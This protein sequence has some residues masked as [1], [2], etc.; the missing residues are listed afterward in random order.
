M[1]SGGIVLGAAIPVPGTLVEP[2][3]VC[4]TVYVPGLITVMD[5]EDSPVLHSNVPV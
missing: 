4:V 3:T 1:G 5:G 2:L